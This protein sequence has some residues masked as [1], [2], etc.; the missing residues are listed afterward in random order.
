LLRTLFDAIATDRRGEIPQGMQPFF[1]IPVFTWHQGYL[2]VMYQRQYIDSAQRFADAMPLTPDH[3]E[4]LN[5]FDELANDPGLKLTM[6]LEPGDMQFVYNHTLLHDRTR[7]EDWAE[8]ERRR[9]LLRLWLS[10]PGDRP[11]PECFAQRFGEITIGDRGGI[12]VP[13]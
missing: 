6:M 1:E 11:L 12:V 2:N 3:V 4:A 10:V 7:F 9:H 5:L 13:G 8:P